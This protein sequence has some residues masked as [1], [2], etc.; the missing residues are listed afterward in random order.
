M[1]LDL[2]RAVEVGLR[3]VPGEGSLDWAALLDLLDAIGS[4]APLTVEVLNDELAASLPP[5][6]LA[7]R[8]GD[9][10]RAVLA[11]PRTR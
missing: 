1:N 5:R 7:R 8:L 11:G 2:L 6:E 10:V 3:L 4:P 9:A